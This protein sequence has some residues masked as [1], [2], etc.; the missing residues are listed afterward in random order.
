MSGFILFGRQ[1]ISVWA[2][3]G[4]EDAY[5]ITL[6]LIVP[7]TVDL[8]QNI[9]IT[10]LQAENKLAFRSVVFLIASVV[11]IAISIPAAVYFGGPGCAF[12]TG[13]TFFIANAIIMNVYYA[14]RIGI[15]I[16]AFWIEM[17]KIGFFAVLC[18][19]VGIVFT[20]IPIAS[21]YINLGIKVAAYLLLFIP[22]MWFFVLNAYEK[23]LV[24]TVMARFKRNK[25]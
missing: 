25:Q 10:I 12:T 19:L 7:F 9:G 16:K 13:L 5:L 24:K 15:A 11:N 21:G 3:A 18:T 8:I 4:F 1:F 17:A 20:F 6:F 14:R 23:N 2:G 22:V